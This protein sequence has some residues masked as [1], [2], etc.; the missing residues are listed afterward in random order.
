MGEPVV[1]M[2][3]GHVCGAGVKA[4]RCLFLS[5]MPQFPD[6]RGGGE[7]AWCSR[8]NT[9]PTAASLTAWTHLSACRAHPQS[10]AETSFLFWGSRSWCVCV[11]VCTCACACR[12]YVRGREK[13]D[14]RVPGVGT[15]E[16]ASSGEGDAL[17]RR[18]GSPVF[19]WSLPLVWTGGGLC[20]GAPCSVALPG[21]AWPREGNS[22]S[23]R[24]RQDTPLTQ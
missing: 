11:R 10:W 22:H 8:C 24:H 19:S 17:W 12:L 9:V 15:R 5:R 14:L 16:E 23:P 2:L 4:P 20:P 18:D 7:T 6:S 21:P 1:S 3:M 13:Q